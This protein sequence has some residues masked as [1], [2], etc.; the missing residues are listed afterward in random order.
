MTIQ[1]AIN[2]SLFVFGAGASYDAGCKMSQAMLNAL[3]DIIRFK[4]D[5]FSDTERETI[6]FLLTCLRYHAEWKT[7]EVNRE[8]S[9]QPNIEELALLIRR[10]KNRE[11]FLPY[12]ITGNW[13]DKLVRLEA[14]FK[15]ESEF[16][17]Y[18][19][20]ENTIKNVLLPKWLEI[21]NTDFLKPLDV[22]FQQAAL[23]KNEERFTLEIFSMNYD[24]VIEKHFDEQKARPYRGFY[25]GEWR[26]FGKSANNQEADIINLYK[27]HGSLDWMRLTDGSVLE[28]SLA[29]E[30][31][32][33]TEG[34]SRIEHDPF[35]IFGHGTKFF[36][37]EPFFSLIQNFSKKLKERDYFFIIG[38]SFFDP[39]INNLLIQAVKDGGQKNKK[40]IVVNPSFAYNP[41]LQE[42]DFV[43]DETFGPHLDENNSEAKRKLTK[44]LEDIQRNAFYSELPEFNIK[45]IPSEALYYLKQGTSEFF[46]RYFKNKGEVFQKLIERF[47]AE[48]KEALPF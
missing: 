34:E 39:Y 25:S 35:I 23:D 37:V 14:Q 12:P 16:G 48:G 11:H 8:Y 22:F 43:K 1:E 46:D 24:L 28:K 21:S 45:Q 15:N 13:A 27:L 2:K 10:I 19:T 20:I 42:S 36:S 26:G 6:K 17:L 33:E 38:Y 5:D 3:E 29:D 31:F 40:I 32:D 18:H 7:W 41:P 44:Y 30:E 9:M 47:D 4:T